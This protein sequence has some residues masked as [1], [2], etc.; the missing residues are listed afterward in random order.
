MIAQEEEDRILEQTFEEMHLDNDTAN[1]NGPRQ[2]RQVFPPLGIEGEAKEAWKT[3]RKM[4]NK[5][6]Q[7]EAFM[8]FIEGCISHD[9]P[10][11]PQLVRIEKHLPANFCHGTPPTPEPEFKKMWD[12]ALKSLCL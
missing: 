5:L 6:A 4:A 7:N 10:V 2:H 1:N 11:H 12:L 3:S 8:K 9:P